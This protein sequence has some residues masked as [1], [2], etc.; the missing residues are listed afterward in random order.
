MP[1]LPI[2]LQTMFAQMNQVGKEQAIQREVPPLLQAIQGSE[3][4]KRA[5]QQDNAVNETRE[6]GNG[7]E[8]VN[9]EGNG[10][11]RQAG[12]RGGRREPSAGRKAKEVFRD[13]DLGHHI[14]ISG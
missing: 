7:I 6:V 3:L 8:Q 2:D 5:E 13:P 12:Q 14:D 11:H 9:E 10:A 1:F 4:A